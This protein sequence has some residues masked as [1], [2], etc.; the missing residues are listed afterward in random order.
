MNDV[1]VSQQHR[2]ENHSSESDLLVGDD[3]GPMPRWVPF[4]IGLI[5]VL[6]GGLAVYT[7]LRYRDNT[8]VRIV[9]PRGAPRSSTAAPPG[10]PEAGASLV[11]PGES[12]DNTPAAHPAVGGQARA[13]VSGTAGAIESSVRILAR[14]GMI[15]NVRPPDTMVYVN[16]VPVG[17]ASQFST[18]A[19][20]F[21]QPGSYNVRL[22]A[23]GFADRALVVTA[24]GRAKGEVARIE[25]S[26]ARQ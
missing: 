14:R 26:L 15:M 1:P 8:L 23:P 22:S 24:D 6:L 7:G 5:L 12:G 10:E 2:D 25:V 19:Y 3:P 9:K 21:P 13:D 4:V 11:F 17:Q 16:D 18:Q 20:E